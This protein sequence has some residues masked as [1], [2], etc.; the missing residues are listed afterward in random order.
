MNR[1]EIKQPTAVQKALVLWMLLFLQGF[2]GYS[3][4]EHSIYANYLFK[5]ITM[6]HGLNNNKVNAICRDEYGFMWFG[7]NEGIDRFDGYQLK[8]YIHK[9]DDSTSIN[10]DLIR[11]ILLDNNKRM[12]IATDGGVAFY[13]PERDAFER[14]RTDK[15]K[16]FSEVTW[17]II[18]IHPDTL[19][20][21]SSAGLFQLDSR[22]LVVKN[23]LAKYGLPGNAE[24]SAL[25]LDLNRNLYV[26]TLQYGVFVYNL[27]SGGKH[28]FENIPDDKRSLSGNR[29]ECIS[30][31]ADGN[32]WIGTFEDGLNF[33]HKNS[34]T[35]EWIDLDRNK[36]FNIRIRDIVTDRF[37]RLW[38]GT[39]KGLYLKDSDRR[40]FTLYAHNRFGIS[41]I[42]HNSIYDIY[43]DK[44]DIMWLGTF[45]G[46]VN[47]CDFNQKKF[48]Q[49][50]F[51]ESNDPYLADLTI[52]AITDD[53]NSNL[54]LGTEKAGL[55]FYDSKEGTFRY[56]MSRIGNEPFFSG[57]NIKSLY[58]DADDN[59]WIGTYMGGLR[60]YNIT[61][62][63]K[64]KYLHDPSNANSL[65]S[66]IIYSLVADSH[67]NLWIGTREGI[68][69]LPYKSNHFVRFLNDTGERHGF[70]RYRVNM[71]YRDDEDNIWIGS[72]KKGLY[73]F[74]K[75]DSSFVLY[76]KKFSDFIIITMYKDARG[77]IWAG[78]EEGLLYL[79]V[80][81]DSL[82][83]YTEKDGLPTKKITA[84]LADNT[85]NLWI[86]TTNGFVKFTD[87]LNAPYFPNFRVFNSREDL[88][89]LQ[90]ANNSC[91]K[92]RSGEMFLGGVNGFLS[93]HPQDIVNNH[94][95]PEVKITGLRIFNKNVEI[96]QEINNRVILYKSIYT[97]DKIKLSHKHYVVTFEFAAMH[98]ANPNENRYAYKLEGFDK[99]WNY[100][101]SGSRYA[102]YSNLSGR[103]YVFKVKASNNDGFWNEIPAELKIRV[104]PPIWKTWWFISVMI[105]LIISS[106]VLL[107]RYR[108][109]R[110]N[111]QKKILQESVA[112][113]TTELSEA[114]ALLEEKQE[115]IIMQ[116]E[117]LAKHRNHLE[118]LVS[119]RT[120][121]LQTARKKAEEADKLKSAFLANM[122]HEI[123]TPMNAILGFSSLLVHEKDE[124]EKEEY[125]RIINSNCENLMVVINDILDI[126]LIEAN[127]LKI[128]S[129]PFD[130]NQVLK[131]LESIY[132]YKIKPGV[133]ILLHIPSQK[134]LVL[135]TDQYRFRQVL[136]N[137]LS[138]AMKYTEKGTVR[139]GYEIQKGKVIFYVADTGIGIEKSDYVR[140]FNYFQKLENHTT[141]LYKGTGIGL[142]ICKKLV[143]ILGGE[144]WLESEPAK[145]TT[146]FFS[147]PFTL[148]SAIDIARNQQNEQ[149]KSSAMPEF[150]IIVAEDEA[151]NYVLY[152][153]ILKPMKANIIWA[154]NGKEA[155]EYIKDNLIPGPSLIIM[156]I[157]M[158][159]MSGVEAYHEIRK[160]NSTI[161][162]IAVTAYATENE[163][164]EILGY[165]FTDYLSK[166][167]SREQLIDVIIRN[168]A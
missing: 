70:G 110:I 10:H 119:E 74:N 62:Q 58:L 36:N 144:I 112:L 140:I 27:K 66:D 107:F 102:T 8:A 77:N 57:N 164:L 80:E 117:E 130:A 13:N 128:E 104:M 90:F 42:T 9:P 91:Y 126:S 28:H 135:V 56:F 160:V 132:K 151:T 96:G 7:T 95:L 137:L 3:Q 98:Y 26:G 86:T 64:K 82:I 129:V 68:D 55:A 133:D 93:F 1:I 139:F 155:V 19:L 134:P 159:V 61:T 32:I 48:K 6:E 83:R 165:G 106:I 29:I 141:R 108:V 73:V 52:F 43:I 78:G 40:T 158:P 49:Y 81:K 147:I 18:E 25:Y 142:S 122:S 31:D 87:A 114:N 14:V 63:K 23:V 138:N 45:S 127:Q 12:W 16:Q 11:Y 154:K 111:Q 39:Y 97:T 148:G 125:V 109:Y 21:A 88:K 54:W 101:T 161:P 72:I 33:L 123:R 163:R 69:L 116:N 75:Q 35:F 168:L 143:D 150:N 53:K 22:T 105:L 166:P 103:K 41:E 118:E 136:N 115:E 71:V 76:N 59:L 146:F 34:S 60:C 153:R 89:I 120:A 65:S 4:T 51:A 15:N 67:N 5:N 20:L 100:V 17:E 94:H 152:E 46:G 145:G 124:N 44:H 85:G 157:K 162:I 156:D 84:I 37:G 121:E 79:D 131:E 99:E 167:I 24:V 38:V 2:A 30:E 149:E 113:R 92:A 50:L 47:Y